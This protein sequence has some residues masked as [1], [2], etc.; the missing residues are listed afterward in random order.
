[1]VLVFM[2]NTEQLEKQKN[3]LSLFV[4]TLNLVYYKSDLL[5]LVFYL[6]INLGYTPSLQHESFTSDI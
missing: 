6:H 4:F 3:K 5:P 1:M 2:L